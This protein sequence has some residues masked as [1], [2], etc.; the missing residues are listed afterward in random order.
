MYAARAIIRL[1]RK[2]GKKQDLRCCMHLG[3][4]KSLVAHAHSIV[5]VRFYLLAGSPVPKHVEP[6]V[7]DY[8]MHRNLPL[9][10]QI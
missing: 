5:D 4:R 2:D 8:K 6:I 9:R 3:M 7:Q 1:S 10:F